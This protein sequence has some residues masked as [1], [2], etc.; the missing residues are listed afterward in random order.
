MVSTLTGLA[1]NVVMPASVAFSRVC[2]K[3]SA[4]NATMG[5]ALY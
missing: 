4:V 2:A 1:M 3:T 5:K